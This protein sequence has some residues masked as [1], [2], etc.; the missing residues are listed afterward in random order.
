M[1]AVAPKAVDVILRDG[2]ALRLW[3][4]RREGA[5]SLLELFRF[6]TLRARRAAGG[7]GRAAYL[8]R[9]ARRP[10]SASR[11]TLPAL[12]LG[13]LRDRLDELTGLLLVLAEGDVGLGNDADEPAV[14]D[15]GQPP[16]LVAG[17]ELERPFKVFVGLNADEVPRVDVPDR[18][19]LRVCGL[20]DHPRGDV[21]VGDHPDKLLVVGY[22]ERADVLLS[23]QSR[24]LDHRRRCADRAGILGHRVANALR[25]RA[26][27]PLHVR[28]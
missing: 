26:S 21:S 4:P 22:R 25:H 2:R 13:G 23:H 16:K 5:D 1:A 19:H 10:G 12:S 28:S 3:P 20:G 6:R 11:V 24:G 18:R 9:W 15:N 7:P 17:H 14:L 8:S 27:S